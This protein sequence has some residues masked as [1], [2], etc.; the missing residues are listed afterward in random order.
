MWYTVS[1]LS[2]S[3]RTPEAENDDLFEE[4]VVL[5][6]A[7][8][9]QSARLAGEEY[10]RREGVEY[11]N[12]RGERVKWSFERVLSVY[13]VGEEAPRSGTEVF[14]RFLRKQEAESLSTPFSK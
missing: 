5:L 8:D 1:L 4:S 12:L 9:E 14:S 6:E 2:R 10:A 13:D 7:T 3:R 11:R